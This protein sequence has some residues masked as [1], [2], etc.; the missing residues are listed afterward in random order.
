[1]HNLLSSKSL[2]FRVVVLKTSVLVLGGYVSVSFFQLLCL[3]VLV[4]GDRGLE[5]CWGVQLTPL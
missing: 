1:M 5:L 3:V 2:R 4:L